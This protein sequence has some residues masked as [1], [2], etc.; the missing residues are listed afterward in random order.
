MVRLCRH[1]FHEGRHCKGPAVHGSP[2]CRHH[3]AVRAILAQN[4]N[5]KT[6]ESLR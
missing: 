5:R 6:S 2:F 4:P 1:I 3:G